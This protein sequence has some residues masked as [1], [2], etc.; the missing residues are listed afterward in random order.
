MRLK[1]GDYLR[2]HF[3]LDG[4]TADQRARAVAVANRAEILVGVL[5]TNGGDPDRLLDKIESYLPGGAAP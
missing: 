2:L 5:L 4:L 3:P 1:Q